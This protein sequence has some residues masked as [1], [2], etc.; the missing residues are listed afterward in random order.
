MEVKQIYNIVNSAAKQAFGDSAVHVNDLSSLIALGDTVLSSDKNKEVWTNTLADVIGKTVLSTRVYKSADVLD[1]MMDNFVFGSIL[2]KIYV[3]PLDAIENKSW[4]VEAGK[5][6]DQYVITKPKVRQKL[7]D[8]RVTWEVDVTI[9]DMQVN[10][11]FRSVEEMTAFISSIFTAVENSKEVF[12]AAMASACY[13]NFIGERIADGNTHGT[14]IFYPLDEYTKLTGITFDN[15]FKALKD[16][17]FERYLTYSISMIIKSMGNMS[18]LFNTE[19]YKRF[20]PADRMRVYML[21]DFVKLADVYLQSPTFHDELTKLPKFK[22]ILFWQGSGEKKTTIEEKSTVAVRTSSGTTLVQDGI[23]GL[24]CDEEA[25][26]MTYFEPSAGTARNNKG[27]YTNY[28]N[29][30]DY[31]YFNDLSENGVVICLGKPCVT[32][33]SYIDKTD[34]TYSIS[35]DNPVD[36]NAT[37]KNNETI[38]SVIA[39]GATEKLPDTSVT[40]AGGVITFTDTYLKTLKVNTT[41]TYNIELSTNAIMQC[42][43]SIVE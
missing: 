38:S 30:A 32:T 29:F 19:N 15:Y 12:A 8:K 5:S 26:G 34:E 40:V 1:L 13:A 6:V 3:E 27:R 36:F 41:Y 11:A 33:T 42:A 10:S 9:P 4:E 20:T 16:L 23:I 31:G 39:Y 35:A 18:T 24:I 28:F 21:A 22:E 43:I 7:F 37:L 2:Q 17:D 14:T 25:I